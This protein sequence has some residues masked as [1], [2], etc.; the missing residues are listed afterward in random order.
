ML[1]LQDTCV[2]INL[3]GSGK[4]EDIVQKV[5]RPFAV[6][7]TAVREA[8]YLRN[9]DSG[10]REAIDL[11][12]HIVSGRIQILDIQDERELT[13]YVAYATELDDGEAMSLALAECRGISL[14]TDDRKARRLIAD[15]SLYIDLWS[16]VD[17]LK[18]WA[19]AGNVSAAQMHVTLEQISRRARY[20]PKETHPDWD[21]WTRFTSAT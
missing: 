9:P 8:L 21:W 14:A 4:F 15:Q 5:G 1:L 20:R 17:I 16:T 3:L 11:Q 19:E 12:T 13:R 18:V 2:L 7:A 6:S 10:E